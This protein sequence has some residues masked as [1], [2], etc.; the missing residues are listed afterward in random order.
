MTMPRTPPEA[1][2]RFPAPRR[3]LETLLGVPF[4]EGNRVD[5]LHNGEQT[6]PALLTAIDGSSHSIDLLWFS[7]RDGDIG[8]EMAAALAGRARAGVRV[9]VLL[10]GYGAGHIGR[11]QLR[12]MRQAG[13]QVVFYRP[14]PSV[15]PTVWN[16]RT[17]RRVLI[18]DETLAITGGTGIAD[19]WTGDGR[20]P[21]QWRETAFRVRGPAV[22][23]LRAAFAGPWLQAQISLGQ[24]GPASAPDRF[25]DLVE[26][27]TS[28]VQALRPS[29]GPGWNDAMLAAA[30]LLQTARTQLRITTP[31]VR[32]PGWL[33]SQMCDTA[34]RG[35]D[36]QLLVSGPHVERPS[37]HL[38][39]QRDYQ[40]LLD[41]GVQIWQYQP[42]LMHA[43]VL[44]VDGELAM[45]GTANLD[46][47]SLALNEQV[48]LL[49]EDRAVTAELDADFDEDLR[50]SA[51]VTT[52]G[53]RRR[54]M[55]HRA[56][57]VASDVVG[58]PLRGWG[59]AGLAGRG[60]VR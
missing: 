16:L 13:C 39:G 36:V 14:I 55:I 57:E 53:W 3:V 52:T 8:A 21:G 56:L 45:V 59:G 29:S 38:Q 50:S 19:V 51:P 35:V 26:E 33:R 20:H 5:V 17:H 60:P 37:V 54:P 42:S 58:R 44:T 7:W 40:P 18:C 22:A 41:A 34:R 46:I 1:V 4:T 11:G 28:S 48:T 32:L 12:K 9:R 49:V 31:Y 15:R 10:D 23:G 25:P 24:T 47:R 43:K 6:F 2:G 27:G 30:V